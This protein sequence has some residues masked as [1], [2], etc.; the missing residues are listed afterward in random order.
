MTQIALASRIHLKSI[1]GFTV[2]VD[3]K[4][5]WLLGTVLNQ[6]G[7]RTA[8]RKKGKRGQQV[9]YYSLRVEDL[10]FAVEVLEYR[11][12]Q[13]IERAKKEQQRQEKARRHQARMQSLYGIDPPLTSVSTPAVKGDVYPLADSLDTENNWPENANLESSDG[14]NKTLKN[15]QPFYELFKRITE[16]PYT[17]IKE[18]F[19]DLKTLKI[20]IHCRLLR[21]L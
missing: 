17:V 21:F 11:S 10:T 15:L 20:L 18:V 4:P 12:Q 9:T 1:L 2:P 19:S 14:S 5:M 16:V 3:C 8:A 6:L 13:R 7:L